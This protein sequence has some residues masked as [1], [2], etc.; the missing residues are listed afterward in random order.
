MEESL[1]E[2]FQR[3]K[4]MKATTKSVRI[5]TRKVRLLA[6]AVRKMSAAEAVVTLEMV[7]KHGATTLIK[8][9]RSAV[10]N[11]VVNSKAQA[12]NLMIDTLLV[13]EAPFLKRFRPS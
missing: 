8:T 13:N 3:H 4:N 12:E 5:S 2:K 11:A 1:L 9:I 6:D 7:N 10:A